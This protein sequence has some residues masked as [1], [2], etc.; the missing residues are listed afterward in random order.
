MTSAFSFL[1]SMVDRFP[2]MPLYWSDLQRIIKIGTDRGLKLTISVGKEDFDS[3]E[4]LREEHG[5]RIK[6]LRLKF[7]D[8]AYTSISI[9]MGTGGVRISTSK[10]EKLLMASMEMKEA[11]AERLP[12]QAVAM[13]PFAWTALGA[14]V[15][16]IAAHNNWRLS[17]NIAQCAAVIFPFYLSLLSFH[18]VTANSVVHLKRKHEIESFWSRYGEKALWMVGGSALTVVGQLLVHQMTK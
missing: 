5:D 14:I 2:P 1:G 9:S 3:L 11:F 13:R 4:H 7:Y 8:A 17:Q 15:L 18:Y 10:D 12:V 16:Y 6:R